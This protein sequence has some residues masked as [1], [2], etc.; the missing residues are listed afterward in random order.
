MGEGGKSFF[1]SHFLF[2]KKKDKIV[3]CSY[4]DRGY[5]TFCCTPPLKNIPEGKI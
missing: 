5:H 2:E 1:Y 3:F 4:C